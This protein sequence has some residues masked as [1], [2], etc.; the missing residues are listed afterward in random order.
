MPILTSSSIRVTSCGSSRSSGSGSG[1]GSED[2]THR[3]MSH[4]LPFLFVSICFFFGQ[5]NRTKF[6]SFVLIYFIIIIF[7]FFSH[8]KFHEDLSSSE[9]L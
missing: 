1:V 6:N 4:Q 9:T 8:A 5:D 2:T 7:F 3:V